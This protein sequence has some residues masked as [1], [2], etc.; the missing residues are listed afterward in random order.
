MRVGKHILYLLTAVY[1]AMETYIF[2]MSMLS[3]IV[4]WCVLS[5]T[6]ILYEHMTNYKVSSW[7]HDV[8]LYVTKV[9]SFSR[10]P[11]FKKKLNLKTSY[12]RCKCKKMSHACTEGSFF[13]SMIKAM[14][15]QV[16]SKHSHTPTYR[17]LDS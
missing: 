10:K 17:Q 3:I 6:I 8:L 7:L 14:S 4:F 16:G 1:V 5:I 15:A 13:S 11:K 2:S 12:R 9:I